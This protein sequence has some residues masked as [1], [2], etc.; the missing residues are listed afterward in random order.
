MTALFVLVT[1]AVV[2]GVA[3]VAAGRWDRP[4]DAVPDRAP[5]FSG[6]GVD[7]AGEGAELAGLPSFEVVPRGYRMDEV[8][9]ALVAL[10]EENARLRGE[11]R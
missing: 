4:A 2:A 7:T 8:D 6:S 9:A 1:I 10:R 3:L 5:K 11:R